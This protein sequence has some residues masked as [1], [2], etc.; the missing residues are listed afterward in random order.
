MRVDSSIRRRR[1]LAGILMLLLTLAARECLAGGRIVGESPDGVP[2]RLVLAL[3]GIPYDVFAG[4]QSKG[5]FIGFHPAARMVSTFPSLSDVSFAAIGG[6]EPPQGYQQMRF[7][8]GRNKV[9]GNTLGSLS[10]QAHPDIGEDSRNYSSL[11]RIIG[12]LAPYHIALREMREIGRE[13]L[14]S[15]T[16]TFVA[17]LEASDAVLHVEGRPAAEKF[18][19]QLDEFLRDLQARVRE[20]TGRGLFIDIVS[21]HGSTMV[22]GRIV[23]VERVLR[24][25]GFQRRDRIAN[26]Y[27]VAYSLAG[28]IGSLAITTTGEHGEEAARCLAAAEGVDLVAIGRGDAVGILA[29]DGEGEVRLAGAAPETYGYRALRGDPLGLMQGFAIGG[30]RTFDESA[31]FRQT[32]DAPRPDPLRRLW[33]AFHGDVKE[34]STILVSFADGREAGN[35]QVRAFA[36]LRGRVGTH[37]SMTRLSTLGVIASNWRNVEDVDARGANESLFGDRTV[38]AMRMARNQRTARADP[39]AIGAPG[40]ASGPSAIFEVEDVVA[41]AAAA[42]LESRRP[43]GG[44]FLDPAAAGGGIGEAR[45]GIQDFEHLQRVGLPVRGEMECAPGFQPVGDKS[46]K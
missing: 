43:A 3:D 6:T 35:T 25:C 1:A 19:L 18:L 44:G 5:H 42:P 33:R 37:G 40:A 28:I 8:A 41:E 26:P 46:C 9:V 24:R 15:R 10:S 36:G 20:R 45:L 29:S 30:E 13:F 4:L 14:G 34:P 22:K 39:P 11:H 32:L 31:L 12:Y 27:D 17:F 38:I 23:P 21:D 16:E 7:D 2:L